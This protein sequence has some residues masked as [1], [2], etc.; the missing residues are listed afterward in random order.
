MHVVVVSLF[1]VFWKHSLL[2]NF[3]LSTSKSLE[4]RLVDVY[5]EVHF[6]FWIEVYG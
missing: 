1:F 3:D 2:K 5:M 4:V 6:G